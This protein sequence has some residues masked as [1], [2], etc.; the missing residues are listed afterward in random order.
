MTKTNGTDGK[1]QMQEPLIDSKD[2]IR[3]IVRDALQEFLEAEMTEHLQAKPYERSNERT[4]V[5]NG[6]KP[7]TIK[8]KVGPIT[9]SLPQARDGSFSTA[10]FERFQR[11]EKAFVLT[12]MKMYVDGVSSRKVSDITEQLCGTSFSK[13]TVSRLC[14]ALDE[15]IGAWKGSDLSEHQ[16][17]Y[18]F[19]DATY[20]NVRRKGSVVSEGALIVTGVR[21]DGKREILDCV[22]AD[23]ESAA[24]YEE[25]FRSLK[26][27]GL[28][29]VLLVVSDAHAG[30]KKAIARYFQGAAWQ[31]CQVHF[32]RDCMSKVAYKHRKDLARDINAIFKE[33]SRNAA[34][35]KSR[36]VT[37]KW[38]Q[39]CPK[40]SNTIEED[41][42]QCLS[43]LAFPEEHRK[44]LRTNNNIERFNG[45]LRRRTRVIR[46]FP[47]E[48]SMIRLVATLCMEQSETWLTGR[49]YLD[50][51]LLDTDSKVTT[52]IE[53]MSN[54]GMGEARKAS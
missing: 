24:T 4:G 44:R 31:R 3:E 37:D 41:I 48:E 52:G 21:D 50:M 32:T 53:L 14:S 1:L 46:V 47:D 33:T 19:V 2:F 25:L 20:E 5:R 11:S 6:Y 16:Y 35:E 28:N 10:L 13:S 51:S 22:A 29:G 26:A 45:E 39:T 12:I 27:R 9:L 30:L 43:V 8:M 38:K 15:Q 18:L 36:E 54:G 7:R 34:I 17:P 49:Q 40:V 42:E 23:T